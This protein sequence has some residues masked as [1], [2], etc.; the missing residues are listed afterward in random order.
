MK[1]LLIK[2]TCSS[3]VD[4]RFCIIILGHHPYEIHLLLRYWVFKGY[5][6]IS[7]PEPITRYGL[8]ANMRDL[9]AAVSWKGSGKLYF[10][11]GSLFWRYDVSKKRLDRSYPRHI[12]LW[13]GIPSNI[14]AVFQWRNKALYF[15]KGLSISC[16]NYC[17]VC[18]LLCQICES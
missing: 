10:F 12:R 6:R 13:R 17:K 8:K 14:D 1:W 4:G 11:K 3:Y 5:R 18:I 15:F 16:L 2:K 7:G 9:D